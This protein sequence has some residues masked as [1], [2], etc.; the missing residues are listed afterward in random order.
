MLK[1][2]AFDMDDTLLDIN[3]NAFVVMLARDEASLLAD[4]GR[5]R[6]WPVLAGYARA[7]MELNQVGRD[8]ARTNREVFDASIERNTGVVLAD[9]V[10]RDMIEYYE[11]EVLPTRNDRIIRARQMPGAAA[12]V[13]AVLARGLRVALLTNPS[14][15]Q[16][17]IAC[18][19][20]WGGLDEMPFEL[21]TTM[22][23]SRHCKPDAA[24][25]RESLEALGLSPAEVLMVGN[26]PKR[27]FPE[28]E[29]GL[30]TAYVG[31]GA[32]ERAIWT[33]TM[34]EFA[35]SFDEVAEGFESAS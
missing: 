21:V 10:V 12:A 18:R 9:P 32:P 5:R 30:R 1:A 15:S 7:L 22:E 29:C 25:Y 24:Y 2:V 3:L 19:M 17:C 13:D 23:N 28:P 14:F 27:D 31:K 8:G 33:G 4:A 6:T 34:A 11:R 20:R 35:E 26:D 16:T